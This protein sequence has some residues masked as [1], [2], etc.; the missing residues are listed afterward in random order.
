MEPKFQVEIF[1]VVTPCNTVVEYHRFRSP[2]CLHL[3]VEVKM[4][5]AW[6]TSTWKLQNS[7]RGTKIFLHNGS[8]VYRNSI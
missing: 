3:Q 6:N 2:C 8:C 1:R 7:Y 4:E 5:A